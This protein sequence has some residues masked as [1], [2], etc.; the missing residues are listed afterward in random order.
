MAPAGVGITLIDPRVES[1]NFTALSVIS[2]T[3]L[4]PVFELIATLIKAQIKKSAKNA[5][6][7]SES[8]FC[9]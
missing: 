2:S 5:I 4:I 8:V 6:R 7:I 3:I 9:H 1:T